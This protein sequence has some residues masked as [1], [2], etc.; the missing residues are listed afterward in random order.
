MI[1]WSVARTAGFTAFA[2]LTFAVAWGMLVASR[3]ARPAAAAVAIHRFL[4]TLGLA[5]IAVHVAAL[6][7]D[8]YAKVGVWML[9]GRG[10]KP[11]LVAGAVAMW[12]AI[13]LPL[14]FRLRRRRW[15]SQRAWRALHWLGYAAWAAAYAHG[16]AA[17]TDSGTPV[18]LVTYAGAGGVVAAAGYIRL[19]ARR[20]VVAPA[21]AMTS[22]VPPRPARAAH[23]P[24][25]RA[26]SPTGPARTAPVRAGTA[27]EHQ[28]RDQRRRGRRE[29]DAEHPVTA[30]DHHTG[31]DLADQRQAVRGRR[32]QPRPRRH[33]GLVR[34]PVG[35]VRDRLPDE[36]VDP[37]RFDRGIAAG[38]LED[39]GDPDGVAVAGD[40][41]LRLGQ[42]ERG[43]RRVPVPVAVI[44]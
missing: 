44:E 5:A 4:S 36:R 3:T 17:G 22:H 18:A 11:S 21:R 26:A 38:Q 13:L 32:A 6:L 15:I 39:A 42:V 37:A 29:R 9:V 7:A 20:R 14:S 33:R 43:R 23:P 27:L 10:A 34:A 1:L 2:T 31:R 12:I 30:R 25:A 19:R 28:R 24:T 16:V 35:Q 40:A 41:D 8:H